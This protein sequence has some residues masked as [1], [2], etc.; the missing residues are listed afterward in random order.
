MSKW[1]S[2]LYHGEFA[3]VPSRP[4]PQLATPLQLES[5]KAPPRAT[6]ILWSL[7]VLNRNIMI[8]LTLLAFTSLLVVCMNIEVNPGPTSTPQFTTVF[9]TTKRI[10]LKLIRCQHHL[11]NYEFYATNNFVPQYY[12][13]AYPPLS[14]ITFGFTDNGETFV[15]LPPADIWPCW[16][17][18]AAWKLNSP[19]RNWQT[20]RNIRTLYTRNA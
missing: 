18:N 12:C 19:T 10:E 9:T 8:F 4:K 2:I 14:R 16:S 3:L 1:E 20:T 15:S 7:T 13:V 17:R 11:K 5:S 6:V